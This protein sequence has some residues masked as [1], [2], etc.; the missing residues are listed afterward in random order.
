[1]IKPLLLILHKDNDKDNDTGTSP[2]CT[3]CT[4]LSYTVACARR[5]RSP[6]DPSTETN[7]QSNRSSFQSTMARNNICMS[8]LWVILL[9]F[10]VWPLAFV[11]GGIWIFLQPFDQCCQCIPS[12][13]KFLERLVTWP[14]EMGHAI[15][16]G[17]TSCPTP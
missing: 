2:H 9:F 14:R 8:I 13:N 10:I 16:S 5:T 12:I 3:Y 6:F 1:M 4:V 17:T 7:P 15:S 11:A